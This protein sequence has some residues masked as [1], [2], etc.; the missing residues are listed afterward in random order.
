[1]RRRRC[2][3]TPSSSRFLP[4]TEKETVKLSAT[5]LGGNTWAPST[6]QSVGEWFAF[7]SEV[8][9]YRPNDVFGETRPLELS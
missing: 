7:E 6:I 4:G 9:R 8:I 5:A 1:M 2:I 3:C